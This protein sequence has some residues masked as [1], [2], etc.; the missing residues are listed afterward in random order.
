M[1]N[2]R[3]FL[4][5]GPSDAAVLDALDRSIV[6]ASAR[7]DLYSQLHELAHGAI[8]HADSEWICIEM[9]I[10]ADLCLT[11]GRRSAQSGWQTSSVL[12]LKWSGDIALPPVDALPI[13][14]LRDW[15]GDAFTRIT[16]HISLWRTTCGEDATGSTISPK[17][18]GSDPRSAHPRP[19]RISYRLTIGTWSLLADGFAEVVR[20]F[21][22][23]IGALLLVR[24]VVRAG[25]SH[26]PNARAFVLLILA[27]CR[28]YGRRSEPDDDA[29]LL[30]RR[31]LIFIGRRPQ[32]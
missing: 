29:S 15:S 4:V 10:W 27:T 6:A 9:L 2:S 7:R 22:R 3:I 14:R 18:S 32:A 13:P 17:R 28:R 21:D 19:A 25:L 5:E 1:T 12:Q 26:R 23:M 20:L 24:M 11:N 16:E 30:I 8:A 31:H